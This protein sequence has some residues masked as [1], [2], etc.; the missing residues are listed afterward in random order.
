[1]SESFADI[2]VAEFTGLASLYGLSW[3]VPD[4]SSV[5]YHANGVDFEVIRDPVGYIDL[6]L[7]GNG[8][9]QIAAWADVSLPELK[10]SSPREARKHLRWLASFLQQSCDPLLRGDVLAFQSLSEK[11][12]EVD[13]AYTNRVQLRSAYLNAQ[14]ALSE[15][16]PEFAIYL[17]TSEEIELDDE[18]A[19]LLA[20]ARN[21]L[22]KQPGRKATEEP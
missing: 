7:D 1:M 11:A 18:G 2:V 4:W 20:E 14:H 8:L 3:D 6:L 22:P 17:L 13:R 21:R 16:D 19:A 10:C 9:V 12:L 15:R 5:L